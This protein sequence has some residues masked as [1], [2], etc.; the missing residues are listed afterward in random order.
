MRKLDRGLDRLVQELH[1][2]VL[3][4]RVGEL[5]H[6]AHATHLVRLVDL[7]DLEAPGQRRVLLDMLLVLGPGGRRDRLE[8]AARQGGLQEIGGV[9]G[10]GSTAGADQ[11]V[12][13]VDEHDDRVRRR[14]HLVD[15]LAQPL[16]EFALHAGAGLQQADVEREQPH[17][18]QHRRH[19]ALHDAMGKALDH[20]RL[21]DARLAR[22]DRVVLAAAHQDVDHL[23]DLLVATD[24]RIDPPAPRFLGQ[25]D[26]EAAKRLLLAHLRR[27]HVAAGGR[28]AVGKRLDG[29]LL[30]RALGDLGEALAQLV[31]ADL[32]QLARKRAQ[33]HAK[34]VVLQHADQQVPAPH[35][36]GLVHQGGIEPA[37]LDRA[38]DMNREVR[39][40]CAARQLVERPGQVAIELRRVELEMLHRAVQ[41]GV[42]LLQDLMQPVRQ[43]DV[44]IAP[45]LAVLGRALD[46]LVG[47]L[48]ELAEQGCRIDVGH[49]NASFNVLGRA[50]WSGA[51]RYPESDHRRRADAPAS[52][53]SW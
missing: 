22:E 37:L 35:P 3:L 20:R 19:V 43:L 4:E 27:R 28:A 24:D 11:R 8:G 36:A 51:D 47:D 52:R 5:A 18:R 17:A 41:I 42:H 44:R 33:R 9:A 34:I 1:A 10:A 38:P 14:L 31:G 53:T 12:R 45:P 39:R 25:I 29:L 2:V 21:A 40:A 7:D 15:H 23:A 49:G 26:G 13:L 48:G 46:R 50:R 32:A 6:H 16:L 30:R